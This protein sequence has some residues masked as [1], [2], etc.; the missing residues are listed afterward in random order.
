MSEGGG[1]GE[2]GEGEGEVM[3]GVRVGV[4]GFRGGGGKV[5]ESCSLMSKT[6]RLSK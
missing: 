5:F 3:S 6:T 4:L 2:R 1:G